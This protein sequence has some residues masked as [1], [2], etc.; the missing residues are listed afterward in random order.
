[1]SLFVRLFFLRDF[2]VHFEQANK[3]YTSKV[4]KSSK[5]YAVSHVNR[6]EN[7]KAI[8]HCVVTIENKYLVI[9]CRLD[10]LLHLSTS[11]H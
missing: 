8:L 11:E 10:K 2:L 5:T 3:N 4:S 9:V 6:I 1:V 7:K